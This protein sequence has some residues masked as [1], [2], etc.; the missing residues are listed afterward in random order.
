MKILLVEDDELLGQGVNTALKREKYDVDWAKD[1]E[2]AISLI[3]NPVYD[4]AILDLGL[5]KVNG[6]DVLRFARSNGCD[7]PILVL[8]AQCGTV[9]RVSGLDSGADDYLTKP[10]ELDELSA[11]LRALYRR[12]RGSSDDVL[13]YRDIEVNL[14]SHI[15]SKSGQ[16]I[17]LS[18]REFVLLMELMSNVGRIMSKKQ[19]EEKVYGWSDNV[20]SNTI[21]VFIHHLRKKF[22][23]DIITTVRGVGYMVPNEPKT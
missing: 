19:L 21:E 17:D 22:G 18:R 14:S 23:N 2:E 10:F 20:D 4:V 7:I 13:S 5:P 16:Q 6:L 12:A 8:T 15:A 9:D 3:T 11:R 1:G